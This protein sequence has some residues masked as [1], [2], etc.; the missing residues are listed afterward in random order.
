MKMQKSFRL[1]FVLIATLLFSWTS[2]QAQDGLSTIMVMTIDGTIAPASQ[3]YLARAVQVAERQNAEAL[4]LQLN[5][6]GGS[7]ATMTE[8][9]QIIRASHVPV[10]VYITPS[11][12]MAGS[13]GTIITLAGHA[14][15][16]APET[17][18]GA[19][20]PINSDGSDIGE[21]AK[22][23]EI[24]ALKATVRTLTERRG[25]EAIAIAEATIEEARA[26]SVNEAFEVGLIDFVASDLG[27]LL[28]QLDGFEVNIQGE[29]RPLNTA[30]SRVDDI[31]L[32]FIEQLLKMLT[33]PNIVFLL[34]AIGTQAIFIELGSPG[35]WVA[36]FIGVVALALAVYGMGI[37]PVNWFGL[38]FIII[39]FVL[40]ILDVKA[41]THGAL[42]AAGIGSF[43]VGALVLFNSAGTPE[44]ARVSVP[45]VITVAVLIALMFTAILTFALRALKAPVRTGQ[46][47]MLGRQGFAKT[48]FTPDGTVRVGS[49]LWSAEKADSTEA[50]SKGE[51]VEV[52]E[53]EGLRLKVKKI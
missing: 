47:S 16:M 45:L 5:T 21:T 22:A 17:I 23:K 20:S 53:V 46:Q 18:I 52:V 43:I 44:F 7:I 50:I 3:Q 25:A 34:I 4:I 9:V 19:A 26:V 33:D 10:I 12:G 40:F 1:L 51:R 48:D 28:S 36:G 29:T 8:M 6:P 38:I 14:S 35:G 2:A 11:G 13:A 31:P 42:T 32:T 39:S 30:N 24:E 49:E 27:D 37:L 41:P 15:A